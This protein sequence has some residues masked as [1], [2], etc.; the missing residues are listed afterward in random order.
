MTKEL[1]RRVLL[2]NQFEENGEII[3]PWIWRVG[4][5]G[6]YDSCSGIWNILQNYSQ[7]WRNVSFSMLVTIRNQTQD[8]GQA[9][10]DVNPKYFDAVCFYQSITSLSKFKI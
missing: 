5:C 6:K 9:A 3:H 4:L 8:Q 7:D 2:T 1:T 10:P